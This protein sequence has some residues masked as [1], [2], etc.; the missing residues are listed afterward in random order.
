MNDMENFFA[1]VTMLLENQIPK[2]EYPRQID[3]F[4]AICLWD[5]MGAPSNWDLCDNKSSKEL[6]LYDRSKYHHENYV[7]SMITFL[8]SEDYC[9]RYYCE[10]CDDFYEH[11]NECDHPK[12]DEIDQLESFMKQISNT[13]K[14]CPKEMKSSNEFAMPKLMSYSEYC[15]VEN[16][17]LEQSD[18]QSD[19]NH[20]KDYDHQKKSNRFKAL[21][22]QLFNNRSMDYDALLRW[23]RWQYSDAMIAM[24]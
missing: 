22:K 6:T 17:L 15:A 21:T 11:Q 8:L 4:K 20:M 9:K 19:H 10:E 24:V 7:E 5:F 1:Y 2:I 18:N 23:I 14:C 16:T 12:E 3:L 13:T